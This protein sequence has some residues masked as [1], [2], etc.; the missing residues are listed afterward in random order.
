LVSGMGNGHSFWTCFVQNKPP[1]LAGTY[2]AVHSLFFHLLSFPSS[3]TFLGVYVLVGLVYLFSSRCDNTRSTFVVAVLF[4]VARPCSCI[5][6][7]ILTSLEIHCFRDSPL[8][9]YLKL[10]SFCIRFRRLAISDRS[11]ERPGGGESR[12]VA[13]TRTWSIKVYGSHVE[14]ACLTGSRDKR[15]S[16]CVRTLIAIP[17]S[18]ENSYLLNHRK[19]MGYTLIEIFVAEVHSNKIFVMVLLE[20]SI[21]FQLSTRTKRTNLQRVY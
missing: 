13:A 7:T 9:N 20:E 14:A 18:K 12:A 11:C 8:C 15:A 17:Q 21:N 6:C 4:S 1:I 19:G 16:A 5:N 10:L 2:P 3:C